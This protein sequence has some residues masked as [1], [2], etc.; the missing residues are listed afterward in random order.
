[1]TRI[2]VSRLTQCFAARTPRAVDTVSRIQ[3]AVAIVLASDPRDRLDVLFIK[4][5]EAENDP[6]SGQMGLPGGRREE[7][8]PD[9]L[10]TARRETLEETGIE[11]PSA[12]LLGVLDDLAPVTPVL[13]PVVVRPFV[14]VL[15]RRP[16]LVLSPEVADYV[17]TSLEALPGTSGEA[18]LAIR[19]VPRTMPA[20]LIGPYVVWGMTHRIMSNLFEIVR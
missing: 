8:D 17:W 14:F 15:P 5:A 2:T 18:E 7:A 10:T 11:I 4:R 13:P 16:S 19:G 12:S 20:Y 9:L 1:M 6:W 3:A